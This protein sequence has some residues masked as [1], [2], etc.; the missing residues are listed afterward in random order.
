M[1]SDGESRRNRDTFFTFFLCSSSH[2]VTTLYLLICVCKRSASTSFYT[3]EVLAHLYKYIYRTKRLHWLIPSFCLLLRAYS[4]IG[5]LLSSISAYLYQIC[6]Y[7][8]LFSLYQFCYSQVDLIIVIR[9]MIHHRR[10]C[11]YFSR[12]PS[13]AFLSAIF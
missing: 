5:I 12:V 10:N 1:C 2:S 6:Y 8:T 3:N 11:S 9:I 7:F 4:E 13:Y